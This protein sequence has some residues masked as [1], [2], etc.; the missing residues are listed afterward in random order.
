MT[1]MTTRR[2]LDRSVADAEHVER[3][4]KHKGPLAK[5]AAA[6]GTCR[7]GLRA[8]EAIPPLREILCAE[9]AR[10]WAECREDGPLALL[11]IDLAKIRA[12]VE[13]TA[14]EQL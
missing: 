14:G 6:C 7:N 3:L 1:V 5:H 11:G 10:I 12:E 8:T 4:R 9:G 13:K 2:R